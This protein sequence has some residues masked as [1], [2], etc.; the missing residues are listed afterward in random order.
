ML[1]AAGCGSGLDDNAV[2]SFMASNLAS[3]VTGTSGAPSDETV[4]VDSTKSF[5]VQATNNT[6]NC[7]EFYASSSTSD[8]TADGNFS[9]S[10]VVTCDSSGSCSYPAWN[11]QR[12][13][14]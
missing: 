14:G 8:P 5:C 1:V 7:N 9:G 6:W 10:I 13:G 3:S 4:K 11:A 2:Q 12:V